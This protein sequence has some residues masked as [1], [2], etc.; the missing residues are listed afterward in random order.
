MLTCLATHLMRRP[1]LALSGLVILTTVALFGATRLTID[2]SNERLFL[3]ASDAYQVYQDFLTSFGSD[4]TILVA[5]QDPAQHLL[6]PGGLAA[7]RALTEDLAALPHVASVFSL[8]NALDMTR[9]TFGPDGVT[10]PP[11]IG[12]DELS[13]EQIVSIRN[14]DRVVGTLVSANLH[15]AGF[16]VLPDPTMGSGD[17]QAW[18]D[19]IR[20]VAAHHAIQGKHTYVAGTPLEQ[21]DVTHYLQRD[22]QIMI[23]LVFLLLLGLT[24]G[25]YRIM[26]VAFILLVCVLVSLAWTMGIVGF[27][28]VPL[29]L[30]TSLLSPVMM[31]VSV[32]AAIHLVNQFTASTETGARGIEAVMHTITQVG[33]ACWLTSLTTAMGF[34]SLLVSPVPAIREFALF[35]GLGV[36]LAF[37]VTL[38]WVPLAL[39][40]WGHL[41]HKRRAH[42]TWDAIEGFL[43]GCI[44]GVSVHHRTICIGSLLVLV[45]L[46]PGIGRLTE[47]TDIVRT[48]KKHAP[49]R[50]SS[51]F[52]DQHV[53]GVNA[54]ELIVQLPETQDV[55]NPAL[56]QRILAFSSWLR[57]QPGVTGVHSLVEYL[58]DVATE[59]S[60]SF[61]HT[62][63]L[64][65]A[66][67]PSFPIGQWLDVDTKR[68]R[69]SAR[70][71]AMASDRFL[72]LAR[73]VSRQAQQ[74][75]LQVQLTG[76][77]YL[78]AQMS[79]SLVHTQIRSLGL[80]I[81]MILG[82]IM[83]TLRS[84][85]LGCLAAISNLLPPLMIFGLMGWARIQLSTTTVMIASVALGLIVDD[86]IH[87]LYRYR[88]EKQAGT[89]TATA[90]EVA[91]HHTG[92]ALIV[93]TVILTLGF[94]VGVLGSF[95]PTLHFSFLTGLTMMIALV[96]DLLL[97]PAVLLAWERR[98]WRKSYRG[99]ND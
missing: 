92:R 47:G 91:I 50:V 71:R 90:M 54:L 37:V 44:R 27:A 6:T 49:L 96:A 26:R 7:I 30:I 72:A 9:L 16:V 20:T 40:W 10:A 94:W 88:A 98:V 95:T 61:D 56:M 84:V 33:T 11:L 15:T 39:L 87:L 53:T 24:Y 79:R 12:G 48:L 1:W 81:L 75:H 18:M 3:R 68:L 28:G 58:R 80:A 85:R 38:T 52:I 19:T 77:N 74:A 46:L 76:K 13:A 2:A 62:S 65:T 22:Q 21:H 55:L 25:L 14:Q 64:T 32:S 34:F 73:D 67:S 66:F 60:I 63:M 23:P 82:V 29:N 4:E 42:R 57:S 83:L 51:E 89:A 36:L 59:L 43:N 8:S 70:V 86:T 69:V 99:G 78:L 35:A 5:L 93:T 17:Q 41:V 45:T 97:M 31:V